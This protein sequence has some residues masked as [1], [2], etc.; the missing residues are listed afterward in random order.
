MDKT[1][2]CSRDAHTSESGQLEVADV[3][4]FQ[5]SS[6][7]VQVYEDKNKRQSFLDA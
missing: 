2:V 4:Y 3:S 1:D 5:A 6:S 7:D